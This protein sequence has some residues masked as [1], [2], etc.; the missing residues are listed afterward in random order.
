VRPWLLGL[1][2][3]LV[4]PSVA[5]AENIAIQLKL[6]AIKDGGVTFRWEPLA[7]YETNMSKGIYNP[8]GSRGGPYPVVLDNAVFDVRKPWD[9]I[10]VVV[11]SSGSH[12]VRFGSYELCFI[13][14]DKKFGGGRW[15]VEGYAS[16]YNISLSRNVFEAEKTDASRTVVFYDCWRSI[17]R[18]DAPVASV[19]VEL[20]RLGLRL[21]AGFT[22]WSTGQRFYFDVWGVSRDEARAI[23]TAITGTY[24]GSKSSIARYIVTPDGASRLSDA[25]VERPSADLPERQQLVY[26]AAGAAAVILLV[27]LASGFGRR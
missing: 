11:D 27:V 8:D 15:L 5:K 21:K 19:E 17:E 24:W 10:V 12:K 4:L 16:A 26:A 23:V 7:V 25:R 3:V 13:V 9:G 6:S 14:L 2:A 1:L 22:V 18:L 20:P